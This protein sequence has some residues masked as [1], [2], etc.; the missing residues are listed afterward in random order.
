MS[1][2]ISIAVLSAITVGLVQVVKQVGL[3]SRFLPLTA[4]VFGVGLA[5]LTV[6]V[7]SIGLPNLII[8]GLIAGLMSV[9]LY[10]GVK[11]TV[12]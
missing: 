2:E 9:G 12:V 7:T 10:S 6:S 1:T 5:W 8:S 11:N 3:P 4:L